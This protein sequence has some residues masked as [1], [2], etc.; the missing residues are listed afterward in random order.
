MTLEGTT[1]ATVLPLWLLHEED[2]DAWRAAQEA[3]VVAWLAEHHFKGEKH[4]VLLVPD[5][6]GS[7]CMA[8]AGLGK[9]QGSLSLWHAAGIVDRLPPRRYRLA[10]H[11]TDAE[12]TQLALGFAYGAYRFDRYRKTG[13]CKVERG[14]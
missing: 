11:F 4:R 5:R 2:V 8:V 1:G 3:H 7:A 13:P 10:Q 6:A 12:A 9:R 14:A